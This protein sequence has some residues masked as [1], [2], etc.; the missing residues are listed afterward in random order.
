MCTMNLPVC[1]F[2]RITDKSMGYKH[3]LMLE[4][5]TSKATTTQVK[6][7]I[8]AQRAKAQ[9]I[10]KRFWRYCR[11][12][13]NYQIIAIRYRKAGMS[14]YEVDQM[15]R[16]QFRE[17]LKNPRIIFA[18]TSLF[19]RV[20]RIAYS[21]KDPR[22]EIS[23]YT[24]EVFK[25]MTTDE[26]MAICMIRYEP[27]TVFERREGEVFRGE[28]GLRESPLYI[29][30][31]FLGA[32]LETVIDGT[33]Q[34]LLI[35]PW[36]QRAPQGSIMSVCRGTKQYITN[37]KEWHKRFKAFH[38]IRITKEL[39]LWYQRDR[40]LGATCSVDEREWLDCEI[41]NLRATC[42]RIAGAGTLA[43]IE[44]ELEVSLL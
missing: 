28:M 21:L 36:S 18:F 22:K 34:Y 32:Q 31:C 39:R 33:G 2:S 16:P 19:K 30:A 24:R 14:R 35:Q 12:F 7:A 37:Y 5:L 25:I 9:G 13:S 10:I 8:H 23:G 20:L 27:E 40:W 38:V 42:V 1:V 41:A 26:I 17:H 4:K 43:R 3:L 15:P 29:S 11:Y 44:R 6:I